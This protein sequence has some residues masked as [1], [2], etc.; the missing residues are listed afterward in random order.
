MLWKGVVVKILV[1]FLVFAALVLQPLR[2]YADD[3]P[4][5][6][7]PATIG[8][9][10]II[11]ATGSVYLVIKIH[12]WAKTYLWPEPKCPPNQGTNSVPTTT[13]SAAMTMPSLEITDVS[14]LSGTQTI[15][16]E[17]LVAYATATLEGSGDT[18]TFTAEGTAEFWISAHTTVCSYNGSVTTLPVGFADTNSA[19]YPP[20]FYVPKTSTGNQFFRAKQ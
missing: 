2:I 1:C 18:K 9:F 11:I 6:A 7:A 16:G 8:V 5:Q 15:G 4:P 3:P 20:V 10:V 14:L 19:A 12:G 17:P 13:N